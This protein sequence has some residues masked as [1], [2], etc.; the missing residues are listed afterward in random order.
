M[1]SNSVCGVALT[2]ISARSRSH[3]RLV[4][5]VLHVD[6]VDQ[7]E[8]VVGNHR[9]VGFARVDDDGH[10]RDVRVLGVAD[11][12]TFDIE[13]AA[14]EQ[15]GHAGQHAGFVLHQRHQHVRRLFGCGVGAIYQSHVG[16][17]SGLADT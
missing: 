5:H 12:Q 7:L 11:G 8:Q 15:A 13:A 10:A 9:R 4:G 3:G 16:F 17:L 2:L 6:H 14:A 1:I